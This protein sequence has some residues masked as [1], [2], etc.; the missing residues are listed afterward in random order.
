MLHQPGIIRPDPIRSSPSTEKTPPMFSDACVSLRSPALP[1][2][3]T[4]LGDK[5]GPLAGIPL[6][7][8]FSASVRV[9]SPPRSPN[10]SRMRIPAIRAMGP[11]DDRPLARPVSPASPLQ[12]PKAL[13]ARP[14]TPWGAVI[15]PDV[16][17]R[18]AGIAD[19][20]ARLSADANAFCSRTVF[21][22]AAVV[23]GVVRMPP[24][25]RRRLPV[26]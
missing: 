3:D 7:G 1:M 13:S 6:T 17:P 5:G 23:R 26:R 25:E 19:M 12:T 8:S 14:P 10:A 15:R 4:V 22:G 20:P 11:M 2:A 9:A 16:V 18:E 24:G 21:T